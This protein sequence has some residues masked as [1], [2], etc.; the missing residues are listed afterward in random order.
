MS[1]STSLT[2]LVRIIDDD[3]MVLRSESFLARMVGFQTVEYQSA[4][5]F[6]DKDDMVRPGCIVLDIRMPGMTGIELQNVMIE[7]GIDL[8]I[9]FLTGHGDI[10]MAVSSLKKGAMDFLVKPVD[11]T[12]L[13]AALDKAVQ[14]NLEERKEKEEKSRKISVFNQLTEREKVIAPQIAQG[15][16]NKV[17]A[18]DEEV[19][20]N[21]IKKYRSSIFE[22]LNVKNIV[23][24]SDFLRH[25]GKSG[26]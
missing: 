19:S 5:D 24:L 20:E 4:K 1:L 12:K 7:K 9:I 17:I 6:L 14:R 8:P 13:Q 2:P 15:K 10:D 25:I 21:A 26:E 16:A 18:I 23:E 11:D 22:K 3:E